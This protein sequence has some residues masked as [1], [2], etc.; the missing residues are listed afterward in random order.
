MDRFDFKRVQVLRALETFRDG[1]AGHTIL[2]EQVMTPAPV[3]VSPDTSLPELVEIFQT[4]GFRHLL[5]TD[6][7]GRLRGV[8]SDRDVLRSM[9][10]GTAYKEVLAGIV[11]G[12]L[13]S[14]DLVTVGPRTPVTEAIVTLM[15]HG[16]SCVPVI[17]GGRL[18][19][20]LTNTDLHVLL[21]MLLQASRLTGS[22]QPLTAPPR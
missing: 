20:I 8:V 2:A 15:E 9:G 1:Q 3:C 17:D 21:Q 19:G 12:E 13:M 14:T 18:L 22:E 11:A 16:I 6:A 4:R 7:Q 5:V 10:P